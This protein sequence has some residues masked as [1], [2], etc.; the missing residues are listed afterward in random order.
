[1]AAVS[2][3][4]SWHADGELANANQ[5]THMKP[6]N[7]SRQENEHVAAIVPRFRLRMKISDA[8]IG[9]GGAVAV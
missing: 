1:M 9:V 4:S 5:K 3:N 8:P 2:N 7:S 6:T